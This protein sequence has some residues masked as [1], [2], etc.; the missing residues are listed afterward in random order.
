MDVVSRL[1]YCDFQEENGKDTII[2]RRIIRKRSKVHLVE[3]KNRNGNVEENRLENGNGGNIFGDGN[4]NGYGSG[5]NRN[6]NGNGYGNGNGDGYGNGCGCGDG[7]GNFSGD[8]YGGDGRG[9]GNG[10][11][12]GI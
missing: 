3:L 11:G 7:D 5:N 1:I 2:L 9:N 6:R 12:S 8:G 10:Y 4:G